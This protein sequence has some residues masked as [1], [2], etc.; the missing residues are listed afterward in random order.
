[1]RLIATW[2]KDQDAGTE[3]PSSLKW[4]NG[5][6]ASLDDYEK[7]QLDTHRLHVGDDGG[8][9]RHMFPEIVANVTF[10]ADVQD[11]VMSGRDVNPAFIPPSVDSRG[12]S[13]IQ[14]L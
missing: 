11:W 4:D 12:S 7:H 5:T 6:H 2:K 13:S 3:L 1:M 9:E 10:D 8:M 14:S